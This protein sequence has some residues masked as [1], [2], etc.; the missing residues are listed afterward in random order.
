MC[1]DYSV[2]DLPGRSRA[3][4]LAYWVREMQRLFHVDH[5]PGPLEGHAP[6]A[7]NGR[8]EGISDGLNVRCVSGAE[9]EERRG[10]QQFSAAQRWWVRDPFNVAV[11]QETHPI[12]DG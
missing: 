6:Q 8:R 4:E 7:W 11:R 10:A 9:H 12:V 2:S 5:V 3:Q 1:P